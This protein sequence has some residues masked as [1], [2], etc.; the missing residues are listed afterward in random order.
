MLSITSSAGTTCPLSVVECHNL[1]VNDY[2]LD[3]KRSGTGP[4]HFPPRNACMRLK[5]AG[6]PKTDFL[7][8]SVTCEPLCT[9]LYFCDLAIHSKFDAK[10]VK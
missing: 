7:E 6:L 4:M 10:A 1:T 2:G 5:I 9:F 3:I 8:N